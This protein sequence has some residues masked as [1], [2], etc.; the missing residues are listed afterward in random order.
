MARPRKV[1]DEQVFEAAFRVMARRGPAEW[2]LADVASAAGLTAGALVQRFGSKRALQLELMAR[3]ADEVGGMYEELLER[4]SSPL[5]A[6]RAYAEQVACLAQTAEGFAHHLDYLRLDLADPE[7][8]VHFRRQAETTREFLCTC[9]ERARARRELRAA[10]DF[11]ALARQVDT[12]I[13]GS[14]F[15]WATYR[16]GAALEWVLQDVNTVLAPHLTRRG[17]ASWAITPTE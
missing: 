9:L 5:G 3:Y 1:S 2:T 12:V 17:S 4:Y 16:E 11:S 6:V 14:L 8:H 7:M 10:T 15:T 13:T